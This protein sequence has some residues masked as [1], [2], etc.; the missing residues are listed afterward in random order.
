MEHAFEAVPVLDPPTLRL[1][2]EF[3]VAGEPAFEDALAVVTAANPQSL[4]VDVTELQFIGSTGLR[5]LVKAKRAVGDVVV[6][7][8]DQWMRKLFEVASLDCVF[9][10]DDDA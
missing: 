8:A 4:V 7:G 1:R 10:F 6:T 3:D 2:G 9:R 5:G